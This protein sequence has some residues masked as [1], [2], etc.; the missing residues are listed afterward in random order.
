MV[1]YVY[2]FVPSG[3][4][5]SAKWNGGIGITPRICKLEA[6]YTEWLPRRMRVALRSSAGN[7][8]L[9]LETTLVAPSVPLEALY[10]KTGW[11]GETQFCTTTMRDPFALPPACGHENPFPTLVNV[12][13]AI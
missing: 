6:L 9:S 12:A 11:S 5:A 10:W 1:S 13:S 8:K 3:D 4:N 2:A 7:G